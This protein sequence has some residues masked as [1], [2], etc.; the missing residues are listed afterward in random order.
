VWSPG[1]AGT[2]RRRKEEKTSSIEFKLSK[3]GPSYPPMPNQKD[4]NVSETDKE[5]SQMVEGMVKC[6]MQISEAEANNIAIRE[7]DRDN[8]PSENRK[9]PGKAR[10]LRC[11][12]R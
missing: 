2:E 1:K 12:T 8:K 10:K 5:Y 3:V 4:Y 9:V 6:G 11:L 7:F